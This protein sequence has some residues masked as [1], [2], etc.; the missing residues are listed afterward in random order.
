MSLLKGPQRPPGLRGRLDAGDFILLP[1]IFN[2]LTARIA[3]HVGFDAIYMTGAGTALAQG[4]PDV[5]LTSL[6]EL[7]TNVRHITEVT[8]LPLV[9]DGETGFGN[10]VNVRRTVR[11]YERAGAAGLHLED[12]AFPKKCGFLEGKRVI[13]A[14]EY[15]H[16]L[17]AACDARAN[18][19]TIII[20]RTD[21]L[22]VNGW[23]DVERRVDAYHEAGA[24]AV[25][26][27]GVHRSEIDTYVD[28]VV[29][30]GIPTLYNGTDLSAEEAQSLGFRLQIQS[31]ALYASYRAEYTA[32]ETLHRTGRRPEVPADQR[33]VPAFT[34]LVGLPEVYDLEAR[35]GLE[36]E[37]NAQDIAWNQAFD[38]LLRF[39]EREGTGDVA[40][41]HLEDG[42]QLGAW[43]AE[44]RR[45]S[46]EIGGR[47]EIL[48]PERRRSLTALPGWR[49][50][51]GDGP[52]R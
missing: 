31:V 37:V 44:Q 22:Q 24:D 16:K 8:D 2:G 3:E 40:G 15:I 52:D 1:T 51:A 38:K 28:R 12:Q 49:W 50:D 20:A 39:V 45:L 9:V 11:E 23:D 35:Y 21:A 47:G 17:R 7:L 18:P 29:R 13:S 36:R 6:D 33:D 42:F 30:H 5:G 27:D 19:D 34:D 41:T 26:V 25:F 43:V 4:L 46:R 32:L 14:E 10:P 48:T